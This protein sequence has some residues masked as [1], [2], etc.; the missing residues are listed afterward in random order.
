MLDNPIIE[1]H[2]KP[3]SMPDN[4]FRAEDSSQFK[5]KGRIIIK[6]FLNEKARIKEA[7]RFNKFRIKGS[8]VVTNYDFRKPIK[9]YAGF[10]QEK[11]HFKEKTALERIITQL[12]YN[13][14]SRTRK[15][16]GKL[17]KLSKTE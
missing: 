4:F 3:R 9:K 13:R 5:G 12:Q 6:G 11:M 14:V 1:G 16:A 7:Q 8:M 10:K 2:Y 17:K 15:R